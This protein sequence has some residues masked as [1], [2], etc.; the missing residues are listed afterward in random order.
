MG[1]DSVAR[2]DPGPEA[3]GCGRRGN[4]GGSTVP[5]Q[6][7]LRVTGR[8]GPTRSHSQA[9]AFKFHCRGKSIMILPEFKH[10]SLRAP[11][12]AQSSAC[13]LS[14]C[15]IAVTVRVSQVVTKAVADNLKPAV[16]MSTRG[17]TLPAAVVTNPHNSSRL[18]CG[19]GTL[20]QPRGEARGDPFRHKHAN[21]I[22][23]PGSDWILR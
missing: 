20:Q 10:P 3:A 23:N 4:V 7:E 11:S 6:P 2:A 8:R 16:S 21:A 19:N 13:C 15:V 14:T 22:R 18:R 17:V 12:R 5:S 9:W 1:T